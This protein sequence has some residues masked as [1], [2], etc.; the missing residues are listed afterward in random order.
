MKH[1]L[2]SNEK[3]RKSFQG[4]D[5]LPKGTLPSHF[6]PILD[7]LVTLMQAGTYLKSFALRLLTS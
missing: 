7:A 5:S 3:I 6:L 2:P 1:I 4:Y